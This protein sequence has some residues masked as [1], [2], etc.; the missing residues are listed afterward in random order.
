MYL[1]IICIIENDSLYEF[2]C[3]YARAPKGN[4]ALLGPAGKEESGTEKSEYETGYRQR[5][6]IPSKFPQLP[7]SLYSSP[8]LQVLNL[9]FEFDS[10]IINVINVI[11]IYIIN[12][13]FNVLKLVFRKVILIVSIRINEFSCFQSKFHEN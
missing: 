5:K 9:I 2:E 8:F 7:Q 4:P 1:N 10:N 6:C 13:L 3:P 12:I 11:N